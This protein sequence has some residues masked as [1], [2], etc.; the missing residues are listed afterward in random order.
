MLKCTVKISHVCSY[1]FRSILTIFRESMPS[2][3]KSY[4][5]VEL[6]SKNTSLYVQQCCGKKCFKLWC[7]LYAVQSHTARHS[8]HTTAWN[9]FYHNTAEHITMYFY[10]LIQQNGNFSKAR[11]RFPEDG[12]GGP[13]HVGANMRYF[14]CT[15]YIFYK[16][17]HFFG[18]KDVNVIKM[19]GT[20]IKNKK[21]IYL[22]L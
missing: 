4:N 6:V 3:A 1:M 18:E 20:T 2:L 15:F 9:T 10:W 12:P 8:I 22:H 14:S 21:N 19:D 7:V 5:F 11:H 13:K 16:M 17:V